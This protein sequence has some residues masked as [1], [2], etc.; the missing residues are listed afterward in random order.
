MRR[1]LASDAND[2]KVAILA[3]LSE[4]VP[5]WLPGGKLEGDTYFALNPHRNDRNLGSFQ[6]DIRTGQ[7]RDYAVGEAGRN[8]TSLYAYLFTGGDYRAAF[9]LLATD[10]WIRAVIVTGVTSPAAKPANGAKVSSAKLK[11]IR[12][13]YAGA[14]ELSGTPAATYLHSRGL[15]LTDAWG[16]LRV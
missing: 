14:T 8:A 16:G 11:F 2:L 3:A 12:R 9:R 10:P 6:I 13:T 5:R 15:R 4:L 7:W 1:P